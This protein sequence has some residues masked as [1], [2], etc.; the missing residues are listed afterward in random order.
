MSLGKCG[1][2]ARDFTKHHGKSLTSDDW[3]LVGGDMK[4]DLGRNIE[5]AGQPGNFPSNFRHPCL[6]LFN[7]GCPKSSSVNIQ[8]GGNNFNRG[9]C[10]T[11]FIQEG[12]RGFPK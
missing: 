1:R 5:I 6:T 10:W 3:Q 7:L 2:S 12:S 9:C 11:P 8:P 4:A